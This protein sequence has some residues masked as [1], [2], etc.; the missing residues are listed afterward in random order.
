MAA[1]P[2]SS[3]PLLCERGAPGRR[4]Y[5]LPPLDVPQRPV[6]Q[7]I[8]AQ[9]RRRMPL[10]LPELSELEVVRH[11]TTLAHRNWAVDVGF[12]PLG[13]CTMKYNPRVNELV[14]SWPGFSRLHPYQREESVQ[15]ALEIMDRLERYLCEIAGME[16]AT[17]TPA[18]GAH[19]EFLGLLLIRAY[20]RERGEE[21][22]RREVI[23][24][25]S[26]HGT[27]PASAAMAGYRVVVVPSNPRGGVDLAALKR[28]VGPATAALMLT[29][30]N[31]LGLF[32]EE[33]LDIAETVHQAGGLLYYDGANMNA[34]LGIARPGDMGFDVVHLNLHKTFAT[35]HGGGGPG[36][37]AIAVKQALIPYL[38]APRLARDPATG[39]LRF[40]DP[41]PRSVGRVKEFH[42]HFG[43]LLRAYAYIRMLGAEGLREVAETAVLNANY[44]QALLKKAGEY[45]FPYPRFCKH[46]FVFSA[47][48][49]KQAS[50][51]HAIDLAKR[52]L[53]YGFHPPTVAFPLIV[54]EALMCEPAETETKETLDAF[55]RSLLDVAREA[56]EEPETVREAPHTLPVSR[57]DEVRANRHLVLR[58]Q[59]PGKR[60][61]RRLGEAP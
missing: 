40:V 48:R 13:S 59:N 37:G 33:I 20:H 45:E 51:L 42:G 50:G 24:P 39:R 21:A 3:P 47:R 14:A 18:A 53:D 25:D 5:R 7:L 44:C 1:D 9:A 32:E 52:L 4:A 19:G 43:V 10:R 46:E 15:G 22:C 61:D 29:N 31:T 38:P 49:Q 41:G 28:M 2:A 60:E 23:V 56:R 27:N 58:W 55:V 6:D 36:A 30:P 26:A 11:Y 17:L 35:P 8:P 57:L 34:I 12:Y 16:A 54:E